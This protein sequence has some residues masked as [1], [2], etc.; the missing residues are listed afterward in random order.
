M[1]AD[2]TT[3]AALKTAAAGTSVL[4]GAAFNL[5]PELVGVGL[6]GSMLG[7]TF[8][9]ADLPAW[10]AALQF[11]CYGIGAGVLARWAVS[12]SEARLGVTF[13]IALGGNQLTRVFLASVGKIGG[14]WVERVFGAKKP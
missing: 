4:L 3:E 9:K 2:V 7:L 5:T 12:G 14:E 1:A 11:V 10:R 8:V 6:A 13:L